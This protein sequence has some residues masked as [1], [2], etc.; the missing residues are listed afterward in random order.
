MITGKVRVLQSLHNCP[1]QERQLEM[2][3]PKIAE[4]MGCFPS[5][6]TLAPK[7]ERIPNPWNGWVAEPTGKRYGKVIFWQVLKE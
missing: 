4:M 3:T 1:I 5:A 6:L 2:I 7:Q